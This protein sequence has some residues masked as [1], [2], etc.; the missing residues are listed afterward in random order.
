MRPRGV[1]LLGVCLAL[2]SAAVPL[3]AQEPT[4]SDGWVV[5]PVADYRALR[6]KAYPDDPAPAPPPVEA[7]LTRLAY[8]LTLAGDSV[9][10]T[11]TAD[12]DVLK[13]GWVEVLIPAGLLVRD[14]RLDGRPVSLI[15]QPSP[16]V[17]L[18]KPGRS[19]LALQ[20]VLPVTP[21][22]AA[23]SV[24]VP[25][26][27]AALVEASLQIPRDG[28][29]MTVANGFMA[30]QN[31]NAGRSRW[32][33]YGRANEP[34]TFLWKRRVED[35]RA[36]QPLRLRGSV[37]SLVGL[38][39]DS[40]QLTA[41]VQI[42][43]QQGLARALTLDIPLGVAINQVSGP[44]VADWDT[45]SGGGLHV[46]F[47]EPVGAATS[48]TITGDVRGPHDG[49]IPIPLVRI[50]QA[51][52]ETGGVA[53]EVLGAGE[54]VE[55]QPRA[56]DPADASDL[57]SLVRG[58]ES[59]SLVAF[60]YKAVPGRDPRSL[61]VRVSRYATQAMQV[62]NVDEARYQVLIAE[63]G[64][65]MVKARYAVRNNH[66]GLL[67]VSLPHGATLWQSSVAG[68][69]VRPGRSSE[70][71]LLIPLEKARSRDDLPP[72]VVEMVY[73]V[74]TAAWTEKGTEDVTLPALDLPVSRTG[75]ELHYSPRFRV[76]SS[77]TSAFR[78]EPYSNP[79]SPALNENGP[80][81]E[82]FESKSLSDKD[83]A[84]VA[85]Q[86]LVKQY[87]QSAGGRTVAGI[88]PV[89]VPFPDF[90]AVLFF[91][92]ELTAEARAPRLTLDYQRERGN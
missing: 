33:A 21:A 53:V 38:G 18:S 17:L 46:T 74:P 15:D 90:G 82:V 2:S 83:E 48:L 63:D 29:D 80:A 30:G 64:K 62:A 37:V 20:I 65:A 34:L 56:L 5:I 84:G 36:G 76:A 31:Q 24:V 79:F 32:T 27:P 67:T 91:A 50:P 70:G 75:V 45:P 49:V 22:G 47:L 13:E 54:I 6:A 3:Q 88:L 59:P 57:G 23:E 60:R 11:A 86:A 40:T 26:A 69:A 78:V 39:E 35:Q 68:R 89:Q 72:F 52:R 10:G 8:D 14:A 12:I 85:M 81:T 16:H 43:V 61:A 42:E 4:R 1:V 73:V 51:E 44:L 77:T 9:T 92:A 41:T 66:R 71:A 25:P 7:A 19:Q 58:R 55:R 28:V 87:Q